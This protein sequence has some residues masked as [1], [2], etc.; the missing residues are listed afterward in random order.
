MTT[1]ALV[2]LSFASV[3]SFTAL[4]PSSRLQHSSIILFATN[5][6]RS[7]NVFAAELGDGALGVVDKIATVINE[8]RWE[9]R[10]L[11]LRLVFS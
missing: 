11:L 2:L 3:G 6:Q 7:L 1:R 4:Y 5:E 9:S 8:N 10:V